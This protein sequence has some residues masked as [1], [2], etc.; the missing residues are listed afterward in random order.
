MCRIAVR[1]EEDLK[2]AIQAEADARGISPSEVV[3]E[4]VEVYLRDRPRRET[5]FEIAQRIGLI[6]CAKD[7]PPDLSTNPDY[8]Q[9]FGRS[10]A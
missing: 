3:R 8:M 2:R 10:D 9:G 5:S 4:A 6:G 1:V 7:L